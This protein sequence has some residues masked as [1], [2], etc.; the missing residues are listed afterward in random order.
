MSPR[1]VRNWPVNFVNQIELVTIPTNL[2][3]PGSWRGQSRAASRSP[4]LHYRRIIQVFLGGSLHTSVC[5]PSGS[6]RRQGNPEL[7]GQVQREAYVLIHQAQGEAGRVF[8]LQEIGS[9]DIHD[10]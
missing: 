9:L 3:D 2:P 10:P 7:L 1:M 8:T 4:K 6:G 5:L